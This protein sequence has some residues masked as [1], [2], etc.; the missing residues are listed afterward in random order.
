MQ[1]LATATN[2]THC[3][4]V[5]CSLCVLLAARAQDDVNTPFLGIYLV[6]FVVIFAVDFLQQGRK[7]LTWGPGI[8]AAM[9]R[10]AVYTCKAYVIVQVV[11]LFTLWSF[12]STGF[13]GMLLF[14][15]V[16]AFFVHAVHTE[17]RCRSERVL[18]G[19]PAVVTAGH[20]SH[21][22]AASHST[23]SVAA[24]EAPATEDSHS[25]KPPAA[26]DLVS[27]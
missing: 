23:E 27:T 12:T 16:L 17:V 11:L 13:C 4:C 25:G 8:V 1:A 26:H 15:M 18:A 7:E 3:F 2:P 19:G 9:A 6:F 20:A 14:T 22:L 24:A 10:I 21:G 5:L